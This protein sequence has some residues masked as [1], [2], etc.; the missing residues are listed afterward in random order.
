MQKLSDSF[1]NK[2]YYWHGFIILL[3]RIL[4][5]IYIETELK[6]T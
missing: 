4:H 3:A 5:S 1:N 2:Q 6:K